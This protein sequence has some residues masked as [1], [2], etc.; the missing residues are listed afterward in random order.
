DWRVYGALFLWAP[1]LSGIQTGNL[2]LLLGLIAA[3]AWRYRAKRLLP[4]V[5]VGVAVAAKLFMW[6]L[7]VWLVARRRVADVLAAGGVI[8][9][10][11]LLIL[12]FGSPLD[13]FDLSRRI[14]DVMRRGAF[15]VY[16][17]LGANGT[18]QIAWVA[19]AALVLIAALFAGD[20]SSFTLAI[21]ACI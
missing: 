6:P 1:V 14:A 16:V 2:T 17:L 12:P 15:S 10:S 9:A 8:V 5:L 21:A 13:Y 3:L 11:I 20:R 18:A 4:G 7:L 19:I